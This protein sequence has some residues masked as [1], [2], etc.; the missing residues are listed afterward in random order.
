[1]VCLLYFEYFFSKVPEY[2]PKR[3]YIKIDK[4][5]E[6]CTR[7]I[8]FTISNGMIEMLFIYEYYFLKKTGM[9]G[10]VKS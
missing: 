3:D 5:F 10:R 1:M 2:L 9:G 8:N 4:I 6:I 7:N